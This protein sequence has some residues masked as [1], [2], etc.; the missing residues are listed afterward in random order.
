MS[1]SGN[2]REP[3]IAFLADLAKHIDTWQSD[4]MSIII[5]LNLNGEI[6]SINNQNY[7]Q[8]RG[9]LNIFDWHGPMLSTTV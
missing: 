2:T 3:C 5:G 6:T 1:N 4:G 9:L 7:W 8:Q